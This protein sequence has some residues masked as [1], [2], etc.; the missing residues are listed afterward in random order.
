MPSMYLMTT[1]SQTLSKPV[2]QPL[3]LGVHKYGLRCV[4]SWYNYLGIC[5]KDVVLLS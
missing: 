2:L 1:Q 3:P 4:Y 5:F